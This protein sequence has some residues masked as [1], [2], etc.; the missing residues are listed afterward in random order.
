MGALDM[1]NSTEV[2][3]IPEQDQGLAVAIES[4]YIGPVGTMH[5]SIPHPYAA[6]L[7]TT[8]GL[9]AAVVRNCTNFMGHDN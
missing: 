5:T 2:A 3:A 4:I 7:R 8:M 9:Y 6:V 1:G